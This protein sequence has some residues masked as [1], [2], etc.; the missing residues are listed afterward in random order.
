MEEFLCTCL[1][2]L[3]TLVIMIQICYLLKI[4]YLIVFKLACKN[5]KRNKSLNRYVV[6][7][8]SQHSCH[9]SSIPVLHM[10]EFIWTFY[11]F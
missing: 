6:Q 4:L 1:N 7:T 5:D 8:P 10:D 11:N 3:Y 2:A 9:I